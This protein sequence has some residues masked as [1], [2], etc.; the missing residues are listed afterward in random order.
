[1]ARDAPYRTVWQGLELGCSNAA[2][3]SSSSSLGREIARNALGLNCN[4]L[5][6]LGSSSSRR[7]RGG[8]RA[9][10]PAG[11]RRPEQLPAAAIPARPGRHCDSDRP[12]RRGSRA[13]VDNPISH[14][15]SYIRPLSK[16][17]TAIVLPPLRCCLHPI[18]VFST[19]KYFCGMGTDSI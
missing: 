5:S 1:M 17:E 11:A 9:A 3:T 6:P 16:H 8:A 12:G 10:G 18:A 13:R 2:P 19:I 15:H 4:D 7:E 14:Y